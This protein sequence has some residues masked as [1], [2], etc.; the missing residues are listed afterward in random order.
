MFVVSFCNFV[1][2]MDVFSLEDEDC[3]GLFITQEPSQK[4]FDN[5]SDSEEDEI[6]GLN[7][8]ENVAT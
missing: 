2:K 3:N 1:S 8:V 7:A 6:F 4:A 5:V